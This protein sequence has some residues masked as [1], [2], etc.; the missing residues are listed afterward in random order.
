MGQSHQILKLQS[1]KVWN[2]GSH[3]ACSH[4]KPQNFVTP[5]FWRRYVPEYYILFL[6]C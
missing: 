2:L 5:I 4:S 1:F 3:R 6:R